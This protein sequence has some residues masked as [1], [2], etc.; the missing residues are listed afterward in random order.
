MHEVTRP[1][2]MWMDDWKRQREMT[3]VIQEDPV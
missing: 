3:W 2:V 1:Q